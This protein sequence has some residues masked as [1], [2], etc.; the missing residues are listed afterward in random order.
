MTTLFAKMALLPQGWARN[1]RISVANS[2]I[3][4]VQVN[5]Q[6]QPGDE[7]CY[8]IVPGMPN[9]HSHAFQRGMAGLA[10]VTGPSADTFWTWRKVMYQFALTID[11]DQMETVAALAYVEML[12]SGFTRVGEFHYLHHDR[13]GSKYDDVAEMAARIASAAARTG[14][15]LTLLPAFYAH[16]SFGGSSPLPE[17]RR[18]IND[19]DQFAGL[20]EATRMVT[21][22]LDAAVV[23]IAPHSLR[24]I[25]PN[26]LAVLLDLEPTGPVHLHVAEQEKEVADCL[27]WSGQRPVEWLLDHAPV[28]DRWCLIHATHMTRSET[29][30]L[31]KSGAVAGLCPVTEAN[32]GDGTFPGH[33]YLAADGRF[34][35]G[36]DSNVRIGVTDELRHLEYAQRLQLRSRNVFSTHT[37]STGRSLFDAA[38]LGGQ[39]ALGVAVRGIVIDAPADLVSLTTDS[40]EGDDGDTLLNC[41][42]FARGVAVNDVWVSGRQVVQGGQ[43]VDRESVT[44]AYRTALSQLISG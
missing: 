21:A 27:V 43:H 12:E 16:A 38:F 9:V 13:D 28:N 19:L 37:V 32:L 31:A 24:A 26:D 8:A 30:S 44:M 41:W 33:L 25:T 17:Q 5:S 18:F 40:W 6:P 4:S 22:G 23:G 29:M 11:P 14:I 39:Q 15:R 10:E 1:V 20:V 7:H 35:I 42:I 36:T 3:T 2:L 34:G